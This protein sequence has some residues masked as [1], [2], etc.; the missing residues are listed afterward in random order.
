MAYNL[1][2]TLIPDVLV[3]SIRDFNLTLIV[4]HVFAGLFNVFYL[5]T[6]RYFWFTFITSLIILAAVALFKMEIHNWFL[7]VS[8]K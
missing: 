2:N 6:K 4:L 7:P 5:I 1:D 3:K 8:D